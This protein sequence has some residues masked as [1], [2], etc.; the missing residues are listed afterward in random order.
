MEIEHVALVDYKVN[1]NFCGKP[2]GADLYS[3]TEIVITPCEKCMQ[4]KYDEGHNAR[5]NN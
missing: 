4:G 3:E 2:V 5:S 1:C